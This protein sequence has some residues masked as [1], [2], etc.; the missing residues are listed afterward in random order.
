MLKILRLIP[1]L[2]LLTDCLTLCEEPDSIESKAVINGVNNIHH[3]PDDD[4]SMIFKYDDDENFF[5]RIVPGENIFEKKIIFFPGDY[6]YNHHYNKT[7]YYPENSKEK[8][9][10]E[11]V[12]SLHK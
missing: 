4:L 3:A 8:Y 6:V 10:M 7:V 1:F 11:E 2:L 12:D 5:Y 9:F